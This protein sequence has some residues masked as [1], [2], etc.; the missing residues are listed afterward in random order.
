MRETRCHVLGL[1][2]C[3]HA[4]G[5][6]E[7]ALGPCNQRISA[8]RRAAATAKGLS[9][10]MNQKIATTSSSSFS[11]WSP[12]P[13]SY[14]LPLLCCYLVF[15]SSSPTTNCISNTLVY[16][17]IWLWIHGFLKLICA[18]SER[19]KQVR[20]TRLTLENLQDP[21]KRWFIESQAWLQ[22]PIPYI[23]KSSQSSKA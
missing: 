9:K 23:R 13:P 18:S 5:L 21:T 1:I 8:T 7:H 22:R 15:T 6:G 14:P 17:E 19:I 20:S 2:I 4:N 16:S 12:S 11:L 3:K 10:N